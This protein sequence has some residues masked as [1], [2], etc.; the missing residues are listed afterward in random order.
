MDM[1]RP[2]HVSTGR[3]DAAA[4]AAAS[5]PERLAPRLELLALWRASVRRARAAL[6]AA[7]RARR[8]NNLGY[9]LAAGVDQQNPVGQFDEEVIFGLRHLRGHVVRQLFLR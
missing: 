4:V 3:R 7:G 9:R 6:A 5:E 2:W 1:I 8:A